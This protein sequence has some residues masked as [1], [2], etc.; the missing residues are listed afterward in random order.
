MQKDYKTHKKSDTFIQH[1]DKPVFSPDHKEKLYDKYVRSYWPCYGLVA[2]AAYSAHFLKEPALAIACCTAGIASSIMIFLQR[3][4]QKRHIYPETL[5]T[6]PAFIVTETGQII[7]S[8]QKGAEYISLHGDS[9]QSLLENDGFDE[10]A[11]Y[12]LLNSERKHILQSDEIVYVARFMEQ[13]N[14]Y[15]VTRFTRDLNSS[16]FKQNINDQQVSEDD[17]KNHVGFFEKYGEKIDTLEDGAEGLAHINEKLRSWIKSDDELRRFLT[18]CGSRQSRNMIDNTDIFFEEITFIDRDNPGELTFKVMLREDKDNNLE[19]FVFPVLSH[20]T[21]DDSEQGALPM[22]GNDLLDQ[23]FMDSPSMIVITD[24]DGNINKYNHA[25]T[26]NIGAL[27]EASAHI[28]DYFPAEHHSKLKEIMESGASAEIDFI[29]NDV[30]KIVNVTVKTPQL[31]SAE[32]GYIFYIVDLSEEKTLEDKF[33]QVQKMQAVGQLAGGVA[34]DFNNLLTA[35]LGHTELILSRTPP[36]DAAFRDL[37]QIQ[38]NANR[39]G[40]LVK[41]LLAFSR[42]QTLQPKIINLTDI[43]PDINELLRRLLG[44]KIII[45]TEYGQDLAAIKADVTQFEQVILNLAVNAKDAMAGSGTFTIK[46][47][48]I[49]EKD[50]RNVGYDIMPEGNYVEISVSDTGSGMD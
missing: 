27:E 38:Q 37:M 49:T 34:H 50:S 2:L 23:V 32:G 16:F 22:Q 39:A 46:T 35:I 9:L 48:N 10:G 30:K 21:F 11:A 44:E 45:K 19:G 40:K 15:L 41:Q 12:R 42:Q 3:K 33:N 17:I 29:Q 8:N 24:R 18:E 20:M 1:K 4:R 31:S 7:R 36:G 25:F 14:H 43:L 26:K 13:N 6:G 5:F 28:F 47:Q